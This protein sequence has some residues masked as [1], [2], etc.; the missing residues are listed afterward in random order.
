MGKIGDFQSSIIVIINYLKSDLIKKQRSF[1]IGLVSVF[2]VI[3]FLTL[4]L[5]AIQLSPC[6][7]IKISEEQKS[8]IDLILTPILTKENADTKRPTFDRFIHNKTLRS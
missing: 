3:F 7:F 8:E 1:K 6:I 2:L 5:N 4:L